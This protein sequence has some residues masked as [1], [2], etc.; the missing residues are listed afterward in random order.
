[1]NKVCITDKTFE[2]TDFSATGIAAGDYE[3]C[4]F[5]NCIITNV[6]LSAI[7]F[8]ECTFNGCDLSLV[9]LN[10]TALRDV[11]FKD[12]KLLGLRFESCSDF[13][14][15]IHFEGCNLNLSTFFKKSLKKTCFINC[16]L[17]ETDFTESDLS[18]AIFDQCDLTR[19]IF[20]HANLEKADFRSSVNFSI[21]PELNRMKKARFSLAGIV[22][23]LDKYGI[24]VE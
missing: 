6:D 16:S 1:V 7:T 22:G 15:C 8:S 12:C 11:R 18:S 10:K 9:K 4:A 23:L 19:A 17:K 24:V 20:V 14:F 13:L 3:N 2:K 21:D 5:N